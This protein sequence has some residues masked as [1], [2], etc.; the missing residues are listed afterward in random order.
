MQT[1]PRWERPRPTWKSHRLWRF[2]RPRARAQ[3][4]IRARSESPA[5][6]YA[7]PGSDSQV[8]VS[9]PTW[10]RKHRTRR[11]RRNQLEF[12]VESA[13]A[14][15]DTPTT[16]HRPRLAAGHRRCEVWPPTLWSTGRSIERLHS[17]R[18]LERNDRVGALIALQFS[19]R[20][21][22]PDTGGQVLRLLEKVSASRS[23]PATL[24]LSLP[25]RAGR[26]RRGKRRLVASLSAL[27]GWDVVWKQ[28]GH[29]PDPP[30]VWELR[31]ARGPWLAT[32]GVN[33]MA[34]ESSKVH[35][36][37]RIL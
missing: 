21:A 31:T 19:H 9:S 35:P 25:A 33:R 26:G 16:R 17:H 24:I 13:L 30:K 22:E 10:H 27:G 2:E 1:S 29:G 7:P 4:Q 14:A 6:S 34:Y 8:A 32:T 11:L 36:W 37:D 18:P 20:Q 23:T 12:R 3:S 5:S 28:H 15:N